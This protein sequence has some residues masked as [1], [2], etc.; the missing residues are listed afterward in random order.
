MKQKLIFFLLLGAI[1]N[2][3]VASADFSDSPYYGKS[4]SG[5]SSVDSLTKVH[6]G[7]CVRTSICTSKRSIEDTSDCGPDDLGGICCSLTD[8]SPATP[9]PNGSGSDKVPNGNGSGG[10]PNNESP[11]DESSVNMTQLGGISF[12][13]DTGLSEAPIDGI[14][15]NLITWVL[16]IIGFLGI[17]AFLISGGQYLLAFGDDKQVET[18]KSTMKWSIV[19]I[20]VALS[21]FIIIQ[22][23]GIALSGRGMFF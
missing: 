11:T 13:T 19:G 17:L 12:P 20:A 14:L 7:T 16:G 2:I 22:A 10:D 4:C 1:G 5:Y 21:G 15:F 8:I 3:S 9:D 18:A 23:I 6:T